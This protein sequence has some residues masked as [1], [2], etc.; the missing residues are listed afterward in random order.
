M[1]V[2]TG[3]LQ[4]V[5]TERLGVAPGEWKAQLF[6]ASG[7]MLYLTRPDHQGIWEFA[8][9]TRKLRQITAEKGAG[10]G[11]SVSRDGQRIAYLRSSSGG[12][13]REVVV[14][15][16]R[17][18]ALTV[19]F[20]G[21]EVS[22]PAFSRSGAVIASGGGS[23][24]N[25]TAPPDP[26]ETVVLGIER[27]KILLERGGGKVLF[28]PMGSGNYIWPSLSP[29]GRTLVAYEMASGAFIS[30]LQGTI[31]AKLGR[32]DAPAWTRDGKW[33]V[34]MDDRDDGH[35][36][37]TSEIGCVSPD[38]RTKGLLTATPGIHE[39]WPVCSPTEDR[40]ICSTPEGEL[41]SISYREGVK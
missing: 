21:G 8:L 14:Q 17:T 24:V 1:T 29:D 25:S 18:G 22:F 10:F 3:Q 28:D 26:A 35:R 15:H 7:E 9:R 13:T 37:L 30:D 2:A 40:I 41:Y 6:S 36:L 31:L 39:M 34:Y 20:R 19:P 33:I 32:A 12:R 5:K 4:V 27:G 16:L 11:F 38:G 23:V